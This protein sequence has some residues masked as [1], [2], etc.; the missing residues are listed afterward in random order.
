MSRKKNKPVRQATT[1]GVEGTAVLHRIA[2]PFADIPTRFKLR[3]WIVTPGKETT[4]TD[5]SQVSATDGEVVLTDDTAL[6]NSGEQLQV[7]VADTADNEPTLDTAGFTE[8]VAENDPEDKEF[9][10]FNPPEYL[11]KPRRTNR[12]DWSLLIILVV[13]ILALLIGIGWIWSSHH[14]TET[15]ADTNPEVV[16]NGG[17]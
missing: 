4:T 8:V 11:L 6:N 10:G 9:E 17:E 12:K 15:P 2:I 1:S 5:E 3:H 16:T 7:S 14:R 13:I